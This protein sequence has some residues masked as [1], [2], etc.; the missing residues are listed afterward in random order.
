AADARAGG[1]DGGRAGGVGGGRAGVRAARERPGGGGPVAGR[2]SGGRAGGD[3]P[4]RAPG[5]RTGQPRARGPRRV[6]AGAAV[7][8]RAHARAAAW[9]GLSACATSWWAVAGRCWGNVRTRGMGDVRGRLVMARGARGWPVPLL[10]GMA[11]A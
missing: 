3:R 1:G 5:G 11:V 6:S 8:R 9:H 2:A 7:R 4:G 10:A